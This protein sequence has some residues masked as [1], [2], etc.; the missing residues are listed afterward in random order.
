MVILR[1]MTQHPSDEGYREENSEHEVSLPP[2]SGPGGEFAD[3]ATTPG[4]SESGSA[5]TVSHVP[6]VR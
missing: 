2:F 3:P 6:E 5:P 4:A 1:S